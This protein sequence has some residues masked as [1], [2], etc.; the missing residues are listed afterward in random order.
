MTPKT[1]DIIY[2]EGNFQTPGC[3]GDHLKRQGQVF[4][5]LAGPVPLDKQ[6]QYLCLF[7]TQI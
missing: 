6:S 2:S 1:G 3:F 7:R 4:G 5:C